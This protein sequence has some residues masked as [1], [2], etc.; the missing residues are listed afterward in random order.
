MS[1]KETSISSDIHSFS[2][3]WIW[4]EGC[5]C[6]SEN[7]ACHCAIHPDAVVAQSDLNSTSRTLPED[8][9]SLGECVFHL[10]INGEKT[11][12]PS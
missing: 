4:E 6:V 11:E 2:F 5:S 12:L 8:V 3:I 1:L 7:I 10:P 9:I